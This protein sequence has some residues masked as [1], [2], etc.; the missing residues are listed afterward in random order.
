MVFSPWVIIYVNLRA[1]NQL[2]LARYTLP[3]SEMKVMSEDIKK[4]R[5]HSMRKALAKI[6]K[7]YFRDILLPA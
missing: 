6:T 1:A 5:D 3:R 7:N 4:I 2:L